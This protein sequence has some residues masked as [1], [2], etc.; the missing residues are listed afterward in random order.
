MEI[1]VIRKSRKINSYKTI[2]Q[3]TIEPLRNRI[4]SRHNSKTELCR[5]LFKY[6][7]EIK[8]S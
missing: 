7:N 6:E 2:S 1:C 3:L 5:S 4:S 8:I